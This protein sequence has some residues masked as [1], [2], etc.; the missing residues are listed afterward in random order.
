MS[1]RISILHLLTLFT[2]AGLLQFG[3]FNQLQ[4]LAC[5]EFANDKI[6][7]YKK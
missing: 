2:F 6:E 4:F 7:L 5:Q 1:V 3:T